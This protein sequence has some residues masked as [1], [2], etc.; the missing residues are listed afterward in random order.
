[1]IR[2]F[3]VFVGLV[4]IGIGVG[5]VAFSSKIGEFA[6]SWL[7]D[8]IAY[9]LDTR[10]EL[11]SLSFAPLD[12]GFAI[13]NLTVLNPEGFD[14]DPALRV[15]KAIVSFDLRTLFADTLVIDRI[16]LNDLQ[17]FGAGLGTNL[18]RLS[19]RAET[20][21]NTPESGKKLMVRKV[22]CNGGE[23]HG[24]GIPVTLRGFELK[25]LGG[26]KAVSGAK[27]TFLLLENLGLDLVTLKGAL[28][29]L[30]DGA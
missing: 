24:A 12:S 6:Q 21:V 4:L 2:F 30:F 11:E 5:V 23:I 16:T 17:V 27:T 20:V 10:V 8:Q 22:V 28:P 25:D 14:P 7:E 18:R 3:M 15:G 9:A 26:S 13:N 29:A 19:D 1:M